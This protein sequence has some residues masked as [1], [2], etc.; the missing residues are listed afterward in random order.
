MKR[1]LIPIVLYLLLSY[2]AV[3]PLLSAGY[4]PMHDD[5]QVGR[6]VAMG[7]A[8]RNGQF[9]VRWVDDLGYG[10]GYP[11][12]N[13]Y[14]PL[15]YYVGGAIYALGATGVTAAKAMFLVG[16]LVSGLTMYLFISV[17]WGRLAGLVSAVLYLY[18]PYHAVQAYVRGAVGEFWVFAFLPLLPTGFVLMERKRTRETGVLVTGVGLTATILSH[19]LLG[20][21]TTLLVLSVVFGYWLIRAIGRHTDFSLMRA[22]LLALGV[23]F[24][25]SAFFWLPALSEMGFTNVNAQIGP[26]ADFRDHFVCP[27]QLWNSA[28]G[29]GGSA[30]GCIDGLSLKLGKVHILAAFLGLLGFARGL[31]KRRIHT[32]MTALAIVSVAGSVFLLLPVSR[33]VWERIPPLAYVQYPWR[34]LTFT[35]FGLS[36]AGSGILL[37]IRKR[38]LRAFVAMCIIFG[39]IAASAKLFQPQYTYLQAPRNF[40]DIRELRFRVS[41]L[42]DEYLPKELKRPRTADEIAYDTVPAIPGS[43]VESVEEKETYRK[44]T[45]HTDTTRTVVLNSAYFPG[46]QYFINGRNVRALIVEG[47]P[48]VTFPA[49]GSTLEM[50]FTDTPIRTFAN[51]VAFVTLLTVLVAYGKKTVA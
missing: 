22:H 8:L 47:R 48:T 32:F 4:F 20:S 46:W 40:E 14:G 43:V 34:F 37:N 21:I 39:V 18:A 1:H 3:R 9:P 30:P 42:S 23:G 41:K 29:F 45:V 25:L 26:T 31:K 38:P 33:F 13:F 28:W 36:V 7:K 12:F 6:V 5:T 24:G 51:I 35:L 44:Y 19:T 15:P 11:I 27:V 49:G 17:A 16:M 50:R 10:Y 2:W